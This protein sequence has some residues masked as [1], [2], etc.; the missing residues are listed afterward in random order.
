MVFLST[1]GRHF[2][3]NKE[4]LNTK[5]YGMNLIRL[6]WGNK[7]DVSNVHET[8]GSSRALASGSMGSS[9]W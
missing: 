7:K 2:L 5:N 9:E 4:G 3:S 6:R 8:Q 1:W